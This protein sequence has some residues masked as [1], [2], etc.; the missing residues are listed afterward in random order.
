MSFGG[1]LGTISPAFGIASGQGLGQYLP[2][3]SPLGAIAGLGGGHGQGG[4]P[5][6]DT[7]GAGGVVPP[8]VGEPIKSADPKDVKVKA[9]KD[10]RRQR[11][12]QGIMSALQQFQP[13]AAATGFGGPAMASFASLPHSNQF[14]KIDFSHLLGGQ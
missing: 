10:D 1:V 8:T 2:M 9:P 6:G 7:T 13:G 14:G 5:G 3:A 12:Q 11:M 4:P